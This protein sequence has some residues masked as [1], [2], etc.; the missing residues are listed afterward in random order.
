MK[1]YI[2]ILILWALLV[3]VCPSCAAPTVL[4]YEDGAPIY[5]PVSFA[6]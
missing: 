6:P 3:A 2:A 5:V 1:R 4:L